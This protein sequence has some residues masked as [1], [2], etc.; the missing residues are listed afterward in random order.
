MRERVMEQARRAKAAARR[1]ATLGADVKNAALEAMAA[2]LTECGAAILEAN[3]ADLEAGR[4][5]GL[6]EALLDR[7]MLNEKRLRAMAEGLQ[8]VAALPDPIGQVIAGGR[9]P[10]GLEIQRVRVPLGVVGVIYES[11]PNVTAD[12]AGL[13]LKSG[14]AVILRGGSEA[15]RSNTALARLLATAAGRAGLP[16]D[17]LQLIETTDREAALA[18]M[19]AEGWVDVL[20]PRGGEAL[21]KSVLENATVPVLASL[22]GNCHTYVDSRADLAMATE[23]AFNAKVSRPS[24]CNAMETLLVHAEVADAL[25]PGLGARLAEAGVELRG[26]ERTCAR[27]PQATPATEADWETEYLAL[28]L[29]VRVVDSLDEALDHI[30]RYGTGHSEAI[31]TEDYRAAERFLREVDAACVYV[32]AS[33]RFTDGYEFG[34]GAEVGISTQKLHARG[35][36]GLTELTTYKTLVRGNGQTR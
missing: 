24:V 28:I 34:Q 7:L 8:Q 19:Q 20:L 27:L 2:A 14:N 9:R 26:C 36:I 3:A 6:S 12:A 15:I 5:R 1:L 35:P 16:P 29:A 32:N 13:C 11:R 4:E 33:T 22:G 10:N 17:S 30:A 23:I 18:L 31:V 21:K 25:L